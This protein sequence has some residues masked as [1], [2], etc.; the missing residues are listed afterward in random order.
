VHRLRQVANVISIA[1]FAMLFLTF[2]TQITARFVFARPLPWTDELAVILYIWVVLWSAA[3]VVRD[4]EHVVFDLA[5]QAAS[6]GIRRVMR[7][8]GSIVLV[9]LLGYALA[10]NWDYV[11]FMKREKSPVLGIPMALVFLPFMFLLV[12][13]VV[14]NAWG[15]W[16]AKDERDKT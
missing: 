8:V 16:L 7:L 14:R 5:Y 2:I 13:L 1:L 15:V 4:R 6:P 3:F 12:S 10:G 11:W 9:G